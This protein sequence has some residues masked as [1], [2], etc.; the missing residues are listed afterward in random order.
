MQTTCPT[1]GP[2]EVDLLFMDGSLAAG[3]YATYKLR[4][5]GD[6]GE[7]T[8]HQRY[9][10]FHELHEELLAGH[11]PEKVKEHLPSLPAKS[12]FRKR[13]CWTKQRFLENRMRA[14]RSYVRTVSRLD[15]HATEAAWRTFLGL[16]TST[17]GT[18]SWR[19]LQVSLCLNRD[20]DLDASFPARATS[21]IPARHPSVLSRQVSNMSGAPMRLS[22]SAT[23]ASNPASFQVMST[24]WAAGNALGPKG[25][26][27]GMFQAAQQGALSLLVGSAN[28][29]KVPL[30]SF[31]V[32]SHTDKERTLAGG[33]LNNNEEGDGYRRASTF[34]NDSSANLSKGGLAMILTKLKATVIRHEGEATQQ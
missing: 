8:L 34:H 33:V 15:P 32:K 22:S 4:V 23:T 21:G 19:S 18:D 10:N 27:T 11:L 7:I 12:I 13:F 20:L 6:D 2:F 5:R 30:S 14:L 26:D 1:R 9:S 25:M 24:S 3:G 29:K 28:A 31:A 17:A 16:P